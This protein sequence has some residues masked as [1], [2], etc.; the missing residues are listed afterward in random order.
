MLD[1]TGH[2]RGLT[3]LAHIK[4]LHPR[5]ETVADRAET[6]TG[7]VVNHAYQ[8]PSTPLAMIL[9]K[10]LAERLQKIIDLCREAGGVMNRISS[11]F[12]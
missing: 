5:L 10:D 8:H 2:L 4:E 7:D 12:L 11:D 6:L 1:M 3:S 9:V